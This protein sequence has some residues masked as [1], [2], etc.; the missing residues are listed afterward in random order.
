MLSVSS[1]ISVM[2]ELAEQFCIK[3]TTCEISSVPDPVTYHS[4]FVT[5]LCCLQSMNNSDS[6]AADPA[7]AQQNFCLKWNQ[8]HSNLSS[9]LQQMRVSGH[10][11]DVTML[12]EDGSRHAAHRIVLAAA[13]SFFR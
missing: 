13:S 10:L 7:S 6:T 2:R 11:T 8:F 1:V 12:C 9:S 4:S 5:Q 3:I